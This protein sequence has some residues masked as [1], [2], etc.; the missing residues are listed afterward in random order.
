MVA[1]ND[2]SPAM[3]R[4]ILGASRFRVETGHCQTKV[5]PTG[6]EADRLPKTDTTVDHS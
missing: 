1:G 6:V 3:G 2:H 5:Q 4:R